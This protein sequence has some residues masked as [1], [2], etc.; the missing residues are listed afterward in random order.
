QCALS[1]KGEEDQAAQVARFRGNKLCNVALVALIKSRQ[2]VH[3][4]RFTMRTK[5]HRQHLRML[6]EFLGISRL[7]GEQFLPLICDSEEIGYRGEAKHGFY[8]LETLEGFRSRVQVT[9]LS[10]VK[11]PNDLGLLT[12]AVSRVKPTDDPSQPVSC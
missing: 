9:L 7:P 6:F 10:E 5:Q 2:P 12:P 3:I 8:S 1:A 4:S 11:R